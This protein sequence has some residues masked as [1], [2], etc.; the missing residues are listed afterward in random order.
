MFQIDGAL[1]YFGVRLTSGP[2]ILVCS[3]QWCVLFFVWPSFIGAV[4]SMIKGGYA[5]P[6]AE[7][8]LG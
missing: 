3:F 5:I 8:E 2:L 1:Q 6:T 4:M 7:Q